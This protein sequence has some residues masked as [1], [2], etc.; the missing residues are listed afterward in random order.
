MSGAR[1]L[2]PLQERLVSTVDFKQRSGEKAR[3]EGG[4]RCVQTINS[5]HTERF[6]LKVSLK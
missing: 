6:V 3:L 5:G 1:P 4:K 2:P